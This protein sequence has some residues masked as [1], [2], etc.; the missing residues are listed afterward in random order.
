[1]EA[2]RA[3]V[4]AAPQVEVL[5]ELMQVIQELTPVEITAETIPATVE[6]PEIPEIPET[7]PAVQPIIPV[8]VEIPEILLLLQTFRRKRMESRRRSREP[9]TTAIPKK[10]REPGT[11]VILKRSRE[12]E[13]MEILKK[14]PAQ[15]KAESRKRILHRNNLRKRMLLSWW[16][17]PRLIRM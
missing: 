10:S 11:T 17:K 13:T 5:P 7:I 8:T 2:A 1:M 6:I 3:V 16:E 14:S 4:P 15:E 12:P 9:E